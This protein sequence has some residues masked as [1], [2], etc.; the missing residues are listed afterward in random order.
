MV[1]LGST[2]DE[3]LLVEL[4]EEIVFQLDAHGTVP[5]DITLEETGSGGLAVDFDR[6]PVEDVVVVGPAPKGVSRSE[7]AI[8]PEGGGWHCRAVVDV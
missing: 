3:D 2:R 5:V 6:A 4:L 8:G 1:V 7:L